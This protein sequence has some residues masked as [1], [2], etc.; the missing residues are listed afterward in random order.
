MNGFTHLSLNSRIFSR[1]QKRYFPVEVRSN[2][3]I[4]QIE[5]CGILHYTT[6]KKF[7]NIC[8]QQLVAELSAD[9]SLMTQCQKC[10]D[11]FCTNIFNL[12]MRNLE[13][14]WKRGTTLSKGIFC[15]VPKFHPAVNCILGRIAFPHNLLPI[16]TF[17]FFQL[18]RMTWSSTSYYN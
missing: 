12:L 16:M 5:A 14:G 15:I 11:K 4:N 10:T 18:C 2:I 1:Q 3:E 7:I 8:C 6:N 9:N 17:Y 13:C